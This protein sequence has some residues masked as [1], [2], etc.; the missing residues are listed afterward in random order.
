MRVLF[1]ISELTYGGAQKQVIELGRELERRGH[2]VAIYTLNRDVP[3][4]N[5]AGMPAR[6]SATSRSD[7]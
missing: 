1:I 4:A 6:L 2:A 7:A 3:R 5:Q